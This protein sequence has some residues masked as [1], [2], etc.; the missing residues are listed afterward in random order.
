MGLD[1]QKDSDEISIKRVRKMPSE[2]LW[3]P[4]SVAAQLANY[5]DQMIRHL[6]KNGIIKSIKF[7]RGPVLVNYNDL[8]NNWIRTKIAKKPK[9]KLRKKKKPVEIKPKPIRWE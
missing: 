7:K 5:S 2:G 4:V 9:R 8:E 1:Y 6:Y 3:V